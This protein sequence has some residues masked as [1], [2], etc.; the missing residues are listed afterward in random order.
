MNLGK[1]VNK[2]LTF[3]Y[4]VAI[5]VSL[6]LY[7]FNI[8]NSFLNSLYGI[9]FLGFIP[10]VGGI[11]GLV[12]A[13]HWGFIKSAIG[14]AIIFISLGLISWG[15]GTYIFSGVY[16]FLLNI[17]IPYP[18]IADVGYIL[19]L[20]M[21]IMGVIQLSRA[22]GAKYGLRSLMGKAIFLVVPLFVILFS[23][24]LLIIVAR[25]G[26]IDFSNS[27]ILKLFFDLAY[28]LGDIIILTF[29]TLVYG[30][31]YDYFGGIYKIPIYGIL[32]GFVMMYFADFFFS[33]TTTLGTFYPGDWVDLLF[34]TSVFILSIS[35]NA[36]SS[37][38]FLEKNKE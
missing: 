31:S 12:I 7:I 25:D 9:F 26:F 4:L 2:I 34:T 8:E 11:N 20:P 13:K 30:L 14:K 27:G 29:A 16:N 10:I 18:S 33:Y 36:L 28:P 22:T 17:E 19:S 23:Y 1:I 32:L 37:K 21:W 15:L 35:I 5:V 3:D 38:V 24:Y 6:F